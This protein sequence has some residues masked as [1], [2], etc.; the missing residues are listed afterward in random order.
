EV[1]AGVQLAGGGRVLHTE[2]A[3]ALLRHVD[4]K[5]DHPHPE[6]PGALG[7]ELTDAAEAEDA[8]RLLVQLDAAEPGPLPL[9]RGERGVRLGHVPGE[10]EQHRHRVLGRGDDVGLGR[11][12]HDDPALR[13]RVEVH[14]VHPHAGAAD[15]A[16]AVRLLQ[17]FRCQLGRRPDEDPVELADALL[18]LAVR[19][20]EA[21]LH[22]ESRLAQELE[23]GI[24]DLLLYEDAGAVVHAG[25]AAGT[26]ASRKTAWAA[27]TPA[28]SSTSWP[29]S[30]SVISNAANVVTMSNAPK[31]PQCAIR[32]ILPLSCPWPP[33]MVTPT[34]SRISL[35]TFAP[36]TE[37]GSLIAVTTLAFSSSGPKSSRSS[38][39]TAA[40]AAP[41]STRWRSKTCSRPSSAMSPSATSRPMNSVTAGVNGL[42]GG[43]LRWPL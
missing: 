33:A 26:P 38:A 6:G 21:D 16:Q 31:Y 23:P 7:H 8:E 40:R 34:R 27:P 17:Q 4:V 11:V 41:P 39:L 3:E 22:V 32:A 42:S 9:P 35:G 43:S 30:R 10:S 12:G 28:P 2:L 25:A 1:G 14:V 24:P 36:S 18:Q 37:S 15:R 29:S 20:V 5:G 19:P 13:G